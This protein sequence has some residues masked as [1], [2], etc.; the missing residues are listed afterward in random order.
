MVR[1]VVAF[2]A[3]LSALLIDFI[4]HRLSSTGGARAIAAVR[5][6]AYLLSIVRE[7]LRGE[8]K[9]RERIISTKRL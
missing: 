3:L 2:V 9:S 1:A 5:L 4:W 7:H 6:R 8:R